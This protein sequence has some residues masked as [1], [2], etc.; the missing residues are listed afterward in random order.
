MRLFSKLFKK[1]AAP[2][3][4]DEKAKEIDSDYYDQ[5]VN[6]YSAL[7]LKNEK[8]KAF[9]SEDK[10]PYPK[11]IIK[12]A[13]FFSMKRLEDWKKN[14]RINE[15]MSKEQILKLAKAIG[16]G[17]VHLFFYQDDDFL[18]KLKTKKGRDKLAPEIA[19]LSKKHARDFKKHTGKDIR[20]MEMA[21]A[22][23]ACMASLGEM[24][25]KWLK[26]IK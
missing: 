5:V 2:K 10:L 19:K 7:M 20:D 22:I 1:K 8:L 15:I 9:N 24:D 25:K 16:T 3:I 4:V 21:M 23:M 12:K 11:E 14:P 6:K 17:Y 18:N 26:K 13:L